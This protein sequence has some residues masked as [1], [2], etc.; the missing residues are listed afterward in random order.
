[1]KTEI[2]KEKYIKYNLT[3]D[4]VFKHQ[5]YSTIT[6]SGIEKIAALENIGLS[7]EI[8]KGEPNF[9]S[10]KMKTRKN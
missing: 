4:N 1:M 10:S 9:A 8:V 3:K 5:H 6:R 7:F 2:L